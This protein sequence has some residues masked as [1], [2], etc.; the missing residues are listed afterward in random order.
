MSKGTKESSSKGA[1]SW[2]QKPEHRNLL[3]R[4][5]R[6]TARMMANCVLAFTHARVVAYGR[7]DL[8]ASLVATHFSS[9]E[10]SV[11][12]TPS[13]EQTSG[14]KDDRSSL[15]ACSYLAFFARTAE[16]AMVYQVSLE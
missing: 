11:C 14:V 7:C 10:Y 2:R 15:V 3:P 12:K 5:R 1:Q 9:A 8:L 6:S 4:K 13:I 16:L